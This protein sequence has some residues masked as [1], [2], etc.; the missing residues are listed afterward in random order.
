MPRT[1]LSKFVKDMK[2]PSINS[3]VM[4]VQAYMRAGELT[5]D[6]VG[7]TMGLTGSGFRSMLAR[8]MDSWTL[9]EIRKT[10]NAV[11]CPLSDVYYELYNRN[12]E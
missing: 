4:L 9:G 11:N 10:C 8:P 6:D 3:V 7:R 5:A 12:S 2:R 1:Q